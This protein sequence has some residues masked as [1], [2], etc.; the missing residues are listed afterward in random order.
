M[1]FKLFAQRV[2]NVLARDFIVAI[3]SFFM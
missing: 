2:A 1:F 3:I